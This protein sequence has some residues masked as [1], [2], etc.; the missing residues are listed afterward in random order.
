MHFLYKG[1]HQLKYLSDVWQ[2]TLMPEYQFCPHSRYYLANMFLGNSAQ[3]SV[4]CTKRKQPDVHAATCTV[5]CH[6]C[7]QADENFCAKR[8][9]QERTN[10]Q[11]QEQEL[12]QERTSCW[13]KNVQM[14]KNKSKSW[15]KNVQAA[16]ARNVQ[17][18][19]LCKATL[20]WHT[21]YDQP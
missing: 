15:S 14:Y 3:R 1:F 6:I 12:E 21:Q 5:W 16:G 9:E 2:R 17:N 11:E 8:L 18:Q 19:M 20:W 4:S 13:S 7:I 10:V